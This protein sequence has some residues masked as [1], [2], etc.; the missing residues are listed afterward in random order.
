MEKKDLETKLKGEGKRFAPNVLNKVYKSI[1]LELSSSKNKEVEAKLLE[2][3]KRLVKNDYKTVSEKIVS[4]KQ[5]TNKLFLFVKNP[6]TIS[7]AATFL[8]GVL[9]ASIVLP[10]VLSKALANTDDG[11]T[12]AFVI[13]G[14]DTVAADVSSIV[15]TLGMVCRVR[16]TIHFTRRGL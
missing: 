13:A 15:F 7:A 11:D 2:E 12:L 10:I 16:V 1:G 14:T 8:V 9:S 3:G 5:P 4:K 6:I